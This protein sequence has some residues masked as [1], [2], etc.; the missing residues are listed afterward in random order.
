LPAEQVE[1]T[2]MKSIWNFHAK[3]AAALVFCCAIGQVVVV[4]AVSAAPATASGS[5]ALALAAVIAPYSSLL[6]YDKRAI[7]R[8]FGG[9]SDIDFSATGKI[10]V[11]ADSITCR[12]SN[13]DITARSC[14][15]AFKNHKRNLT[16]REANEL[17]AG[18][19]A[20]G[21]AAQGAAGSMIAAVTKLECAVDPNRVKQKDG[22]GADCT[23]ETGQ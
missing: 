10:S 17:F 9:S 6:P 3:R 5:S 4:S 23:F 7:R 13:V 16:G 2:H 11:T 1:E 8:L 20:A 15:L 14:D 19:A 22:G 21:V 12:I 18:L